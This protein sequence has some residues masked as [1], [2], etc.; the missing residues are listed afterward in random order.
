M[1]KVVIFRVQYAN[2]KTW[3]FNRPWLRYDPRSKSIT[4]DIY[5]N[6]QVCNT[7]TVGCT[8]LKKESVVKHT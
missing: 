7:F 4:C 8:K 5:I 1:S 3:K 2:K 6:A